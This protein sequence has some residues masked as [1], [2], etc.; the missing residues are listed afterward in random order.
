VHN[1]GEEIVGEW[2]QIEQHCEFVQY[3]LQTRDIQGEID[4][5][6]I[7]IE[8]HAI[9]ICEV[10][11][12]LPTGLQYVDP[13]T[14]K[15]DNVGRFLKKFNKNIDYAE[16]YFSDY[17]KV[18]MLWSPI[19]KNQGVKAKHNQIKDVEEIKNRLQ[20][21]REIEL[22]IVINERFKECLDC[23]RKHAAKKTEELKS[24]VL[25]YLQ[26]EEYLNEHLKKLL[27]GK[28]KAEQSATEEHW[29]TLHGGQDVCIKAGMT[30]SEAIHD[31]FQKKIAGCPSYC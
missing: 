27:K 4:V 24:P 15:V 22:Q 26:I 21:D 5:L 20:L 25:R 18:Y 11:I 19:V 23:L 14:K 13:K 7:N 6:G 2:L 28:V 9:Y 29:V 12:H 30:V 31:H 10:A 8:R 1:L 3:N 16:K 17:T